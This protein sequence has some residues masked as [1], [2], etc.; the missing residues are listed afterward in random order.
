MQ[1][2][3][4]NS[5]KNLGYVANDQGVCYGVAYMGI[6][7]FLAD[8][9]ETFNERIE[10]IKNLHLENTTANQ[11]NLLLKELR[12]QSK[13]EELIQFDIEAVEEIPAFFDGVEFYQQAYH[14]PEFFEPQKVPSKQDALKSMPLLLSKKLETEGG[15]AHIDRFVGAYEKKDLINYFR[16]LQESYDRQPE[17]KDAIIFNFNSGIHAIAVGYDPI[18]R[19]W[20]LIDANQLPARQILFID[21]IAERVI[22]AF[23]TNNIAVLS[24]E[25]FGNKKAES[26][27]QFI[28]QNWK[29]NPKWQ[30]IHQIDIES[31]IDKINMVSKNP[32]KKDSR[33]SSLLTVAASEGHTKVV[34][35]ILIKNRDIIND[36]ESDGYTA[37][38][39]AIEH[40]H[41]EIINLLLKYPIDP[42]RKNKDNFTPLHI[43]IRQGYVEIV[44]RLLDLGADCNIL[45]KDGNA[46]HIAAKYGHPNIIELLIK[47]DRDIA[48]NAQY[49]TDKTPL[50]LA[51]ESGH[52]ETV[53]LL[54]SLGAKVNISLGAT[55][56]HV[57][58][59]QGNSAMIELL[60]AH[61]A[62]NVI[63]KK[64]DNMT[65]LLVA[66]KNGHLETVKLLLSNGADI[67]ATCSNGASALYLAAENGHSNVLKLLIENGLLGFIDAACSDGST[68]LFAAAANGHLDAVNILLEHQPSLNVVRSDGLTPIMIAA[69]NNHAEIVSL[70]LSKGA[71]TKHI[72][73]QF[74]AYNGKNVLHIAIE[75]GHTNIVKML[76]ENHVDSNSV[77][78][79]SSST[80]TQLTS[81]LYL[82]VEKGQT[83]IVQL[84]LQHNANVNFTNYDNKT[85]LHIAAQKGYKDIVI[86]LLA[87]GADVDIE[88]DKNLTALKLA[89]HARNTEIIE[90]LEKHKIQNYLTAYKI[91]L[92]ANPSKLGFFKNKELQAVHKLWF[93]MEGK[94]PVDSLK[95]FEK[96]LKDIGFGSTYHRLMKL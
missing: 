80:T 24:T 23:S 92:D 6:Q 93:V 28:V 96:E 31:K 32:I 58:A 69:K 64:S 35:D 30:K 57:A 70:L 4:I 39:L 19:Q 53:K 54:I 63:E 25:V 26:N 33:G 62:K 48:I 44:E 82:A 87:N 65:P 78:K 45:S 21:K 3:L 13:P 16:S 12:K 56:L 34:N 61:G 14:H 8:D 17:I 73:T 43:A 36:A 55:P 1:S 94:K 85:P 95:K 38:H 83:E 77:I 52:L 81:A 90:I 9:L 27:L 66:A 2:W 74:N 60:L 49:I 37:L 47:K 91:P 79:I 40:E 18:S 7:A 67:T 15:I 50:C 29:K 89:E 5:M 11:F 42:N 71:D 22:S 75:K 10:I 88:T 59:Q 68:P 84:L 72:V 20:T 51:V 86:A 41:T 76:L 46:L